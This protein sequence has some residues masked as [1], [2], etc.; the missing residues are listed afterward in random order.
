M[1]HKYHIL[2]V[3]DDADIVQMLKLTLEMKGFS[4]GMLHSANDCIP[5]LQQKKTDLVLIDLLISG[6]YGLDVCKMIRKTPDISHTPVVLM[7]AHPDAQALTKASEAT[8]FISK[9]FELS[10]LL[11]VIQSILVKQSP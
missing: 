8:G 9:P 10:Q 2:V 11:T 3:D 1:H 6:V 7:S 4:A 5:Y